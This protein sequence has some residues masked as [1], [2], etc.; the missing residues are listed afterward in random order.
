MTFRQGLRDMLTS[1]GAA[2]PKLSSK[3]VITF[4]AFILVCI[5]FIFNL[6]WGIAMDPNVLTGMINVVFAGLGVTVG[7]HLLNRGG[8]GGGGE[9]INGENGVNDYGHNIHGDYPN[10]R[11]APEVNVHVHTELGD[12]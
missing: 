9:S 1:G 5:A 2:S 6:V 12:N 11:D 8:G 4:V 10:H 3:R 7:E